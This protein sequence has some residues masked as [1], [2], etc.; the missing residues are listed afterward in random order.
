MSKNTVNTVFMF[1]LSLFGIS[2]IILIFSFFILETKIKA[3]EVAYSGKN[4]NLKREIDDL[5][6]KTREIEKIIKKSKKEIGSYKLET[7]EINQSGINQTQ[8]SV[9][10]DN[11]KTAEF[12]VE[13]RSDARIVKE[14]NNHLYIGIL[15]RNIGTIGYET[16][17]EMYQVDIET[18]ELYKLRTQ[19]TIT[20][21]DRS[22]LVI[23]DISN[24]ERFFTYIAGRTLYIDD[25]YTGENKYKF[26]ISDRYYHIGSALFSPDA[27]KIAF[28]ATSSY[29]QKN[30]E[31]SALII[32]DLN[33]QQQNEIKTAT[34][35]FY[36]IT[37]W[38]NPNVPEFELL[39][40]NSGL[41]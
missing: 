11:Q 32:I 33:T 39:N 34:G 29:E 6:E 31:K 14:I 36:N 21:A 24:D 15:P 40:F 28:G 20:P 38:R 30:G 8:I 5:T 1:F 16:F 3:I 37:E 19:A 13:S 22:S 26:S 41:E 27:K 2:I 18:K 7:K 10:K 25:I 9:Y 17:K 23:N 4:Q 35:G 12:F